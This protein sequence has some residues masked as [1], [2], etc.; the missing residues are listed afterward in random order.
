MFELLPLLL[1]IFVSLQ[2]GDFLSTYK[3]LSQKTGKEMNPVINWMIV[4]FGLV[5]GLVIPKLVA[6]AIGITLFSLNLV[7]PLLGLVAVYSVVV[8]NNFTR[9]FW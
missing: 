2:I 1:V 9:K 3:A 4:H 8:Y 7:W 6:I 5:V